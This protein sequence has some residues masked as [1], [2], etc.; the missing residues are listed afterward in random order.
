M[1]EEV[2]RKIKSEIPIFFSAD[3]NYIPCLSVAIHSL[4]ANSSEEN[5]YR[6]IYNFYSLFSIIFH[7]AMYRRKSELEKKRTAKI[8]STLLFFYKTCVNF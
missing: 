4:I 1:M 3:D 8:T 2:M 5:N 7:Q 6:I